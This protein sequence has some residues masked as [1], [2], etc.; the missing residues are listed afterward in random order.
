[1][2]CIVH[3]VAE[4]GTQLSNFHFHFHGVFGRKNSSDS[5]KFTHMHT[6]SIH[7]YLSIIHIYI[8]THIY[9]IHSKMLK[10]TISGL[11]KTRSLFSF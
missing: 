11:L 4:S 9:K 3:G 1:M 7:V 5:M 6:L 10:V 2:D 8:Y